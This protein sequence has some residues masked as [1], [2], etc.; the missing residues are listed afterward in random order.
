MDFNHDIIEELTGRQNARIISEEEETLLNQLI[1]ENEAAR[2]LWEDLREEHAGLQLQEDWQQY[3]ETA[4]WTK[5]RNHIDD[6]RGRMIRLRWMFSAAAAIAILAVCLLMFLHMPDRMPKQESLVKNEKSRPGNIQLTLPNGQTIDL[7]NNTGQVNI[8][9]ATLQNKNKVLSYTSAEKVPAGTSILTVPIGKDY[10]LQLSDGS[11]IWLNSATTLSFSFTFGDSREITIKG[12]AY[13]KVAADAKKPFIVHLPTTTVQVLGTEFNVNT[14]NTGQET[15]SLVAGAVKM[16]S[17]SVTQLLKPGLEATYT[18]GAG[19][20]VQPFEEDITL[21]W[22]QGIYKFQGKTLE[23]ICRVLP[24]W[25]G[26]QVEMDNNR[27]AGILFS[28][29]LDRKRPLEKQL[30]SFQAEDV[31]Y[32]FKDGVLHFK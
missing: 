23:E 18:T 11:E 9:G 31:Q 6:K 16:K 25:F 3:D 7:S 10:K 8:G 26:I 28:G 1:S 32:Y 20:K 29:V 4:V 13:L 12:E 5:V 27:I 19:F 30:V 17:T 21:S 15:V 14:Y 22:R 24:R 2:Q